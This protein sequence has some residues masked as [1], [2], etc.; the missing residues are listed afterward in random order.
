MKLSKKLLPT[1]R[2]EYERIGEPDPNQNWLELFT[3]SVVSDLFTI[4]RY[5]SDNSDKADFMIEELKPYG[6]DVLGEG[7][8]IVTLINPAYPGVVFKIAL[9]ECGIADNFNDE[10]LQNYIP[11]YNKVL[12]RH[13]SAIVSVQ[14]R[15]VVIKDPSRMSMFR[16]AILDLLGE[17][18]KDWLIA[19]LSPDRFLNYG[20]G[21]DGEFVII[22]GSDLYPL[23]SI[24]E[25]IRCRHRDHEDEKTGKTIYC[26][27]KLH[28][29]SNY[30]Y[31]VCDKCNSEFLPIDFRPK[32]D[33]TQMSNILSDGMSRENIAEFDKRQSKQIAERLG[34]DV[35]DVDED[36]EEEEESFEGNAH[37]TIVDMKDDEGWMQ[38]KRTDEP[39][40]VVSSEQASETQDMLASKFDVGEDDESDTDDDLDEDESEDEEIDGEDTYDT[41]DEIGVEEYDDS[42]DDDEQDS[43]VEI[44]IQSAINKIKQMYE[45]NPSVALSYFSTLFDALDEVD[46][47]AVQSIVEAKSY[48]LKNETTNSDI[49]ENGVEDVH[50]PTTPYIRYRVVNETPDSLAESGI[51]IDFTGDFRKDWDAAYDEYGLPIYLRLIVDDSP[52]TARIANASIIKKLITSEVEDLFGDLKAFESRNEGRDD[53]S[54]E[55][56][57]DET[58][59]EQ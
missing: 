46:H 27:G 29:T 2:R 30:L 43:D 17:L 12:A 44:G 35:S 52:V 56:D 4:M 24:T 16:P 3:P 49:I 38:L 39:I 19:D 36:D 10:I 59:D 18:S 37:R 58:D 48:V 31:L 22:D 42:P 45:S 25:K 23:A 1:E 40:P 28:Y 7:T 14:E 54:D 9:D 21:R 47:D 51:F 5:N 41:L 13:P 20:V 53:E 11:R 34:L 55:E 15:C 57:E 26:N 32:K 33:V 50:D 6:F 8:N